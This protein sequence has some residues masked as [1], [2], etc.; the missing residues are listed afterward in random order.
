MTT[1]Q[2]KRKMKLAEYINTQIELC[3]KTQK[4]IAEESGF[5]KPNM[6]TMIKKGDSNLPLARIPAF[7]KSIG[8]DQFFLFRMTMEEY[9]PDIWDSI[10][11]VMASG[12]AFTENELNALSAIKKA[13]VTNIKLVDEE[14]ERILAEAFEKIEKRHISGERQAAEINKR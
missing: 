1:A 3:G 8:V 13:N 2:P 11:Q 4:Q 9:H 6:I 10:S 7:A 5:P 14:D 12:S